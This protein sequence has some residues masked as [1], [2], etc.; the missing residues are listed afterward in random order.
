VKKKWRD[1]LT[2]PCRWEAT[3]LGSEKLAI[4]K[5]T[6]ALRKTVSAKIA[7]V[8]ATIGGDRKKVL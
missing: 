4:E 1:A 5:A 2:Q 8:G 3:N 6:G 7:P